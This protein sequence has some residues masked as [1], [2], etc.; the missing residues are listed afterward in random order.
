MTDAIELRRWADGDLPILQRTVGDP[1]LMTHLGGPE[2]EAKILDRHRRYLEMGDP[3]R[4][5]MFVI[6]LGP[7]RVPV[8]THGYWRVERDGL[9]AWETGW[10][11]LIPFQ[12]R[13][14]ATRATLSVVQR[15]R[16]DAPDRPIHALPS[17]ENAAS[18]A[19]CRKAGFR[20]AGAIDDEYP[21]GRPIRSNDWV[22]DPR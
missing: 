20:L 10:F 16:A 12:G 14:I 13:G 21:P 3:D 19:V 18:N 1:A 4:G 8:G 9:A 7:E 5:T 2:P 15:A 11:V 17:V 22:L 6:L